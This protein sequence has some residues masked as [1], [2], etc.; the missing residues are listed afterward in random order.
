MESPCVCGIEPPGSTSH[1]VSL[2]SSILIIQ[3]INCFLVF[4]L[5][6]FAFLGWI[7]IRNT[8]VRCADDVIQTDFLSGNDPGSFLT[9]LEFCYY[10][11]IS[12]CANRGEICVSFISYIVPQGASKAFTS[13]LKPSHFVSYNK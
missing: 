6:S 1:G 2:T 9:S 13:R 11:I 8:D 7:S 10:S 3:S 4:T 5:H 12:I